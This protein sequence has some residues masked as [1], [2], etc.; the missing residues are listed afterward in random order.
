MTFDLI[1]LL[2]SLGLLIFSA[3]KFVD[4]SAQL[5][6]RL[7]LSSMVI[8]LTVVAVGTSLPEAL[9]SLVAAIKG[10]PE[11]ALAN[12]VGS[13]I[14]NVGLILGGPALLAPIV[15]R[16]KVLCREGFVMLL[17]SAV[18]LVVAFFVGTYSRLFGVGLFVSF[19]AFMWWVLQSDDGEAVEDELASIEV[20]QSSLWILGLKVATSLVFLLAASWLLV[21]SAVSVAQVLGVSTNVIGLSVVALGTSLPELSVALS[22][23]RKGRGDMLVG[24]ILGSNISNILLVIGLAAMVQPIE[25]KSTVVNLDLPIMLGFAVLMQGFL[26]QKQGITRPRAIAL[27]VAYSLVIL[28]CGLIAE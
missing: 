18:L 1:L 24:N 28:R 3:D 7:E 21:D 10:Y 6:K 2:G 22:A 9:A 12:V 14:C 26:W 4:L 8:G 11:L 13:N 17:S 20:D 23:A 19:F 15:C 16:R 27:L 5:A 25:V